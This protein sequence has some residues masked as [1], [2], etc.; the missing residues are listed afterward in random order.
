[1]KLLPKELPETTSGQLPV[2][3][4]QWDL[5]PHLHEYGPNPPMRALSPLQDVLQKTLD[6][7]WS[8]APVGILR[9]LPVSC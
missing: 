9:V 7:L 8:I 2:N 1:M 5:S 3:F 4:R 6:P